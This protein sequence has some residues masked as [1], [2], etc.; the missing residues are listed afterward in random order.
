MEITKKV[1]E[2]VQM[3]VSRGEILLLVK[4]HFGISDDFLCTDI[5]GYNSPDYDVEPDFE[6]MV[7]T[8][9]VTQED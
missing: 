7:F 1:S 4:E 9:V 6:G 8:K 5:L 2:H 3:S